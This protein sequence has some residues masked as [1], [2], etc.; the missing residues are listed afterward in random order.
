MQPQLLCIVQ[1]CCQACCSMLSCS[2]AHSWPP[3]VSSYKRCVPILSNCPFLTPACF[4]IQV[5]CAI[6]SNCSSQTE[7]SA[8][9]LGTHSACLHAQVHKFSKFI[10]GSSV[11]LPDMVQAVPYWIDD[12][13]I[14]KSIIQSSGEQQ[15]ALL[16]PPGLEGPLAAACHKKQ[17]PQHCSAGLSFDSCVVL[18]VCAHAAAG[19]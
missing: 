13:S 15:C 1:L 16:S 12:E 2:Y 9:S 3:L 4:I 10:H 14:R 8:F 17:W 18:C 19:C 5:M 7:A 6:V 11:L